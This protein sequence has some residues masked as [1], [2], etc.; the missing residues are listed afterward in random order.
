MNPAW[1]SRAH[2]LIAFQLK[3][4]QTKNKIIPAKHPNRKNL[5]IP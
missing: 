2:Y 4:D 1:S 3:I 5:R